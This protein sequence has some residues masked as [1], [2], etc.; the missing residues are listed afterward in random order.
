MKKI[1]IA[2]LL[3]TSIIRLQAQEDFDKFIEVGISNHDSGNYKEA[4]AYY[5][6]A[7]A[8]KPDSPLVNYEISLSYF[9]M[10]DFENTIKY[11]DKVIKSTKDEQLLVPA[12]VN[13]GSALDLMGK[14]KKSI[15]VF[16]KAIKR[17]D[18]HYML[19]FNLAINY[20]KLKDIEKGEIHLKEAVKNNP[21]HASS[22]FYLAKI[23]DG[24]GNK[25]PALLASYYFLLLEPETL[26][27]DEVYT[28]LKNNLKSGVK[29][30]EKENDIV[31]NLGGNIG[32]EFGAVEL[33]I[34]ML[35]A[36]KTL[37]ENEN[38]TD[39]EIFVENTKSIF[40]ILG[41]LKEN[42][43]ESIWW[44]LYVPFFTELAKS[45][46]TE[47]YC[48]FI[49]Q[50]DIKSK[51]WMEANEEKVNAFFEWIKSGGE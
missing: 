21:L 26:R 19:H 24:I 34:S 13:K 29:K 2:L 6:K 36:S 16:E 11:C 8:L 4:I 22:H 46:H 40:S 1:A 23:N 35:E 28:I 30:G 49:T 17:L 3:I 18:N 51:S 33:M 9:T 31:I 27:A 48:Y 15:K 42:K 45:N 44:D 20:L 39:A 41:E 38:K 7:L 25:V 32:S 5:K 47:A 14:T 37:E 10:N 12:Y 50:I 43:K